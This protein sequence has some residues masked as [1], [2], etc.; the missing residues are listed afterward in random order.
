[1]LQ[2]C[3]SVHFFCA[4]KLALSFSFSSCLFE[5]L[6]AVLSSSCHN[7]GCGWKNTSTLLSSTSLAQ[8]LVTKYWQNILGHIVLG[9]VVSETRRDWK[10]GS[11]KFCYG[12]LS[13]MRDRLSKFQG[14]TCK[15]GAD[16]RYSEL[17]S[18]NRRTWDQTVIPPCGW[19]HLRR[20]SRGK[21]CWR[22]L[23]HSRPRHTHLLSWLWAGLTSQEAIQ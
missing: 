6:E 14:F 16:P 12:S 5:S 1:M 2:N 20:I 8:W 3:F 7:T 11:N 10:C 19:D 18:Q 13:C 22:L 21:K 4:C 9:G 17:Q 15:A 23:R